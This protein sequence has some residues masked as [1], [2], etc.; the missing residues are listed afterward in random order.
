VKTVD[1]TRYDLLEIIG[2]SAEVAEPN[3]ASL[4]AFYT[5]RHLNPILNK[6]VEYVE[7]QR[8][9]A[10]A[11]ERERMKAELWPM[12]A[13]AEA[14]VRSDLESKV[15]ALMALWMGD[16]IRPEQIRREPWLAGHWLRKS[17]VLALLKEGEQ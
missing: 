13:A 14:D 17:D 15:E 7:A 4:T 5:D 1:D 16:V 9:A 12:L 6:L 3:S 8:E 2:F 11:D 10:R